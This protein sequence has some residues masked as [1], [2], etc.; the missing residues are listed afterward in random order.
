MTVRN[1]KSRAVR[2]ISET[3][4]IP[5]ELSQ[6]FFASCKPQ[7]YIRLISDDVLFEQGDI[8]ECFYYV[9]SGQVQLSYIRH[10]GTELIIDILGP[11]ALCGEGPAFDGSPHFA[12]AVALNDAVVA[13][14][15]IEDLQREW[16]DNP[17]IGAM[18]LHL[19]SRQHRG[20]VNRL[21]QSSG[22][23]VEERVRQLLWS[24]TAPFPDS[25]VPGWRSCAYFSH[26][27]IAKLTGATR[28]SVTRA[29]GR[30]NGTGKIQVG[31]RFIC[32]HE[33]LLIP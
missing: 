2:H 4:T 10:D 14:L 30:M 19:L 33:D 18:L 15:Q 24:T 17:E 8:G 6:R 22:Y 13:E 12:R 3:A 27:Q 16:S 20:F 5:L 32:V 31:Q 7:G 1:R 23:S 26:S 9:I 21:V 11:G 28:V 29:L 25:P